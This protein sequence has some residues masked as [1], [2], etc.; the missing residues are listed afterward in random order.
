MGESLYFQWHITDACNFR[1]RHC[2]QHDFTGASDLALDGL[3]K[4]YEN[5]ASYAGSRKTRINITGGEPFLRKDLFGLLR[6][7]DRHDTTEELAIITNASLIDEDLLERLKGIKKLRQLKISLDGA[8]AKTNDSIRKAG[9]FRMTLEKINLV[10]E[11]GALE[12]IVMLTAMRSNAYELPA[13]FQL[14]RELKVDGLIIERFIPLGQGK[15]LKSEVINKE[16]WKRLT[17][18]IF[19]YMEIDAGENDILPCKAFWIKFKEGD[20]EL[21]GA[22]CN[23]GDDAFAVMPNGDLLPCRRFAMKIGNLLENNLG[24]IIRGSRVLKEVTDKSKLKGKCA[25]CHID[26]CRGCRAFAY[27]VENDYLAEDS[28]CWL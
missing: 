13:V 24:D 6:Y 25:T 3:I 21:L 20:S 16:D 14:C 28:L 12:V 19:E 17:R 26:R 10:Q 22:E 7:L 1:C 8:T 27:A 4:V 9:A 2:Y 15:G 23:L 5:I 11:K 18:E